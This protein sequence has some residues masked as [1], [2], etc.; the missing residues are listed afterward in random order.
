MDVNKQ[1]IQAGAMP[2][3]HRAKVLDDILCLQDFEAKARRKLPRPIFGYIAGAAEDN[4]SLQDNRTVFKDYRF[5]TQVLTDVSRRD[6]K[7]ELFGKTY[8]APFGIAP[9]G[10]NALST[11]RGDVVLARA[12]QAANIV[13]IMSGS[14]LIPLETVAK[15]APDTWFQAYLPGDTARILALLERV[16]H[17]G[18]QTLVITVD[19][20][21]SANRENNVRTGFST[22]LRP[23]LRL[24]WDG[25]T[26][27][28][29]LFGTFCRTLMQHGMP[30]FEN[31][32]AT[33]GAPILSANVLRDF[34]AR[35][36]L[37]WEHFK[38]IREYWQGHLVIKGVL[39]VKD[40]RLAKDMGAD[41]IILSNHGGRQLDGATSPMR[42]LQ[43]VV[44]ALGSD[45]P[46]M[47][48]SGFRRGSDVL[49]AIALGAKM[50]FVGRPFNYA[51]AVAGDAGVEHAINLLRDEVDRN[52]AMLGVNRCDELDPDML[53]HC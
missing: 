45:Y 43:D 52:M 33:R 41:G 17:A 47:I 21:V 40:A 51:A 46:V 50:V 37:N 10:L 48:D 42:I 13:S 2:S 6:Q 9:M 24:A 14:S 19:I 1:N 30:H 44:Q 49:K 8:H 4:T 35:D 15:A 31:S 16:K 53:I 18:F 12:A 26:R 39:S 28:S 36:H 5:I 23:S 25:L 27:L 34:S 32:F 20:P 11:Y 38:Q 29:W 22:P 3:K 7:V